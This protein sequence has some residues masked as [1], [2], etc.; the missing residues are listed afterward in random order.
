MIRSHHI[1]FMEGKTIAN[2]ESE[3]RTNSSEST[4]RDQ[5][6]ETRVY[7]ARNRIPVGDEYVAA[8]SGQETE[9]IERGENARTGQDPE[10]DWD[11]ELTEE[12]VEEN[13]GWRC[14]LRE[15]RTP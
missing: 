4:D 8:G 10:S 1:V 5:L 11:E 12:P 14:P 7:P 2:W 13:Q 6:E 15:I 3:K 9:E